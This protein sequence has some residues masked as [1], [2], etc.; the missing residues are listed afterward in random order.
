MT[1]DVQIITNSNALGIHNWGPQQCMHTKNTYTSSYVLY[2]H[3]CMYM[4][5]GS[6]GYS[7]VN[8]IVCVRVHMCV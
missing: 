3:M 7:Y 8:N 6:R 4:P 2:V 1:Q 5:W